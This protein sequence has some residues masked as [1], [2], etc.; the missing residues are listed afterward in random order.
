MVYVDRREPCPAE[1]L[2][3]DNQYIN[4]VAGIECYAD[5]SWVPTRFSSASGNRFARLSFTLPRLEMNRG[6]EIMFVTPCVF[7]PR[8]V[9]PESLDSRPLGVQF[10]EL[11]IGG[12]ELDV[13]QNGST[14]VG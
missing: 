6:T 4:G 7:T 5:R 10:I 13:T 9:I 8:E 1:L 14:D 11:R 3:V 2:L 12:P